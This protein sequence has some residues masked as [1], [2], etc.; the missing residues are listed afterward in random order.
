MSFENCMELCLPP[1]GGVKPHISGSTFDSYRDRPRTNNKHAAVDFNY[2]GGQAF[3]SKK[4]RFAVCSPVSGVVIGN[5]GFAGRYGLVSVKAADGYVHTILHMINIVVALGAN[6]ARGDKLGT[7]AG[8]GPNGTH[9]YDVHVHYQLRNPSGRLIDPV[10]FWN[11]D[12]QVYTAPNNPEDAD[13]AADDI[14]YKAT[15]PSDPLGHIEEYRPAQAAVSSPSL[16]GFAL[17]TNRVPRHEPWPRTL[18]GDTPDMNKPSDEHGYN[19][20]HNPQLTDATEA[21]SK[22]IGR[23]EGEEVIERGR[24]WRR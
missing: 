21:G 5:Y 19:T 11:G 14:G 8:Q 7:M 16:A 1:R 4:S 6:I 2:Q 24:F 17:W 12:K 22:L 23:L 15:E 10:A 9:A 13:T 20:N 18:M 3:N